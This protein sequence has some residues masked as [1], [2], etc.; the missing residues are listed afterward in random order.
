M[1]ILEKVFEI[2]NDSGLDYCVQ[3]KYE[4]MPEEI[5]SDIDIMYKDVNEDFL[6]NLISNICTATGGK[7]VQKYVQGF[8]QYS[9]I[10]FYKGEQGDYFQIPLDFYRAISWKGYFNVMMAEEMLST[11]RF[12]K[13]FYIPDDYVELKY[14]WIRRIIKQ[15]MNEKHIEIAKGLYQL[16]SVTYGKRL[17]QDFGAEAAKLAI[18]CMETTSIVP[19]IENIGVFRNAVKR[20]SRRNSTLC[21]KIQNM[22]FFLEKIVPKRI[23]YHCG[24]SIVFLSPDG[25]G[26]TTIINALND[27]FRCMN[28]FDGVVNYYMRPKLFKNLGHY[29]KLKPSEE[30]KTNPNP[31]GKELNGKLKSFIR[32]IFYNFDY[33][34]GG[35][36]KIWPQKVT[37]KLVVFDRYYYDYFVDLKRYQYSFSE[38]IPK[39]FM[40]MIPKPELVIILDAPSEVLYYRKQELTL[41]EIARQR[42]L[43]IK[44][45]EKIQCATIIDVNRPVEKVIQDIIDKIV[46]F[47]E[48]RTRKISGG[49]NE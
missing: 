25:G 27:Y 31:H 1:Y 5:P 37:K 3:N 15:D 38:R 26:K 19:Y 35:I 36:L 42:S 34:F 33:F 21:N 22:T 29:N 13:G 9:Y 11:K 43:Y 14:M 18:Q 8:Y 20:I 23:V 48:I 17:L 44:I 45:S 2:I 12:Y 40:F 4:M 49:K 24:I 32:F 6:D 41:D 39:V 7:L 10:L 16:D 30:E 47:Q 28:I 46:D